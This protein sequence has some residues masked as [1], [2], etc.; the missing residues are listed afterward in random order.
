[1]LTAV[2]R[3][4]HAD[5]LAG[6]AQ[7][8]VAGDDCNFSSIAGNL[9]DGAQMLCAEQD[10]NVV[11]RDFTPSEA[12]AIARQLEPMEREAARERMIAGKPSEKFT[13]GQSMDRVAAA[14]GLSRPMLKR[15]WTL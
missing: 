2:G 13:E 6:F 5:K 10:E 15:Q 8:G 7:F 3:G 9:A 1:L 11:R 14:V 4:T 12:V